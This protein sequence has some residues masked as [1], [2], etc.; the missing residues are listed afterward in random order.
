MSF[1]VVVVLREWAPHFYAV[2]KE[3]FMAT[4]KHGPFHS[5]LEGLAVLEEEVDEFKE[6]CRHG[7]IARAR[8]EAIQC[9]AMAIR[10]LIDSED[11]K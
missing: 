5:R 2:H 9:A 11:W 10:F 8:E 4:A 3:L 7:T 1:K 6:E